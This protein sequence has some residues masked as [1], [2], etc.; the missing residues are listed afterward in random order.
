MVQ[1]VKN[2]Y[3]CHGDSGGPIVA[4]TDGKFVL[5]SLVSGGPE[6]IGTFFSWPPPC[7]CNCNDLPEVHPRVSAVVPWIHKKLNERKLD[8]PC[9]RKKGKQKYTS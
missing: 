7:K 8:L 9:V 6:W 5:V 2:G 4:K 3:S 1:N